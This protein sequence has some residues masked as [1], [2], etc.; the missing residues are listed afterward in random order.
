MVCLFVGVVLVT[1]W[2]CDCLIEGRVIRKML[3]EHIVGRRI[4]Y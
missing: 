4:Q 1:S 2:A 3:Q